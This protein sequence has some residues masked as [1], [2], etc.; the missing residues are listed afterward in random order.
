[1]AQRQRHT[2]RR[3]SALGAHSGQELQITKVGARRYDFGDPYH[4][5]LTISWPVFL[6]GVVA[7]LALINLL[8]AVL[9]CLQ[10][11]ALANTH[12]GSL[13]DAFFFSVE[14]LSTVGYGD[15]APVTRYAHWVAVIETFSG[16]AFTAIVTGLIF[17]RFSRPRAKV[18]Y[19]EHMVITRHNHQPTLMVRFGNGRMNLLTDA[20]VRLSVLLRE[21]TAEGQSFRRIHDLELAR[22][23]FAIFGLTLTVMHRIDAA[24]PLH[25]LTVE[26]LA[27]EEARFFLS[28][29]ARDPALSATVHDLKIYSAQHLRRGMRYANAITRDAQGNSLAD[30][31]RIGEIEPDGSAP[32]PEHPRAPGPGATP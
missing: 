28:V 25:G 5:A 4:V 12:A 29:E 24:S 30:L 10:P 3:V 17:V 9:Y 20:H 16:M 11:G 26:A 14:T 32:P 7:A 27:A 15:M 22:A 6:T 2:A 21:T 23:H 31:A 19:A 18:L 8:F 1:M 13:E